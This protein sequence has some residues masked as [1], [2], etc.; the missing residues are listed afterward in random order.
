M[1]HLSFRLFICASHLEVFSFLQQEFLP[2][3]LGSGRCSSASSSKYIS[4]VQLV[5]EQAPKKVEYAKCEDRIL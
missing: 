3:G 5:K 2:Y 4:P 1:H